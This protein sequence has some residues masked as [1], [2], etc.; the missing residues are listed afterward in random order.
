MEERFLCKELAGYRGYMSR[1]RWR[2]L[3]WLF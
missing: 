3:P 2:I 1:T